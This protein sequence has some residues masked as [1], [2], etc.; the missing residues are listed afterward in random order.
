VRGGTTL[1]TPSELAQRKKRGQLLLSQGSPGAPALNVAV[2][3]S[4]NLDTLPPYLL[5]ALDRRGL[6]PARAWVGPFGQVA[7]T[8]LDSDSGLYAFRPHV[9]ALVPAAEDL[10]GPLFER[11]GGLTREAQQGLVEE[12]LA[13]VEGLVRRLLDALPDATVMV[14]PFGAER[15]PGTQVLCP[16]SP[17]RG[18]EAVARFLDGLR[19]LATLSPRAR[20][21]DWDWHARSAGWAA[22]QDPRLWYLARMRLGPVGVAG[23]ADFLAEHVAAERGKVRKVAVLDLDNTLWGGVV[24]EDGL[25]GLVLGNEALGLAFQDFQ[26]E[27]LKWHDAG[28]VLALCSKNNEP[29]ALAVFAEHPGMVLKREHFAAARVN[30]KDKVENLQE[31]AEELN[32]GLDSFVFL[33]D[34]PVERGWVARAL[35]EVLVPELPPDPAERP[36]FLRAGGFFPRLRVTDTD[37]SRVQSYR[38]LQKRQELR[39]QSAS[40]EDF[41]L[42]LGQEVEVRPLGP[43]T[44]ARSAQMTQRTN[45]FNLTTRRYTAADLERMMNDPLCEVFTLS[46]RDRYDDSGITGLAVLRRQGEDWAVDSLLLSCRVLGRRIE[47]AFLAFLAGWARARG[48]RALLGRYV[49]TAKNAQVA[50]FYEAR[51]FEPAGEE[52]LSR[53]DLAGGPLP[54]VPRHVLLK[55]PEGTQP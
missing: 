44:L 30:W 35:P 49:P 32:L 4:F 25:E 50:N 28:V 55:A 31:L 11:P 27:L 41:L 22:L 9:V 29:D 54:Q 33:D 26:R 6:P 53:L 43:A 23:L 45:Q 3:P 37:R 18:Q 2:L 47:D 20:V 19:R 51:G 21:A 36:A 7:Q 12:R 14:V 1:L 8:V 52:G 40:L 17:D 42:S 16:C 5:E 15:A 38:A 13:E 34:N 39:A 24:G 10:L 46:V 48:A